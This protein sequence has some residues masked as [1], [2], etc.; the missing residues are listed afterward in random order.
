MVVSVRFHGDLK[1]DKFKPVHDLRL[2]MLQLDDVCP[3]V[4]QDLRYIQ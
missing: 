3:E 4:C 2:V 1:L